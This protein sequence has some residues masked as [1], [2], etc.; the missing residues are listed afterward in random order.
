L[1][2]PG[3]DALGKCLKIGSD[4]V[5]CSSVVGIARDARRQA[6]EDIPVMQYYVPLDQ[7][8]SR[9]G[10]LA[11]LV[12]TTG[13]P[14]ALVSP[15]RRTMSAIVPELP[16]VDVRPL[17]TLIDPRI[18]PWRLG[19]GV[20]AAFGLLALLIASVGL[21]SVIGYEVAQRMHEFGIRAALGATRERIVALV[22]RRGLGLTVLGVVVGIAIARA[23]AGWLSPLLFE[24]SATDA[25]VFVFVAVTLLVVAVGVCGAGAPCG[26][27]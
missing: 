25:G 6:L 24:T 22:L 11:L 19:A 1:I 16:Y 2:W 12:R 3:A 7:H 14:T 13:D 23:G 26:A 8:Q 18:Q 5:P 27:Q 21:Y 17:Q 15:I 4:T 10:D 9:S 20:F